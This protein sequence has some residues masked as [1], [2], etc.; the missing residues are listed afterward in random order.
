[1]DRVL[2][3]HEISDIDENDPVMHV[4]YDIAERIARLYP[5]RAICVAERAARSSWQQPEG[6]TPAVARAL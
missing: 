4:L 3:N 6:S 5:E 2:P 1:M